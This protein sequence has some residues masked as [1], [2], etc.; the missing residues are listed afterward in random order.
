MPLGTWAATSVLI[1]SLLAE[2]LTNLHSFLIITTNHAGDDMY[3]F[4]T[5]VTRGKGEF[6]FRQVVGSTN[7]R[8]GSDLNDFLHGF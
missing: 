3:A 6:Y 4:E 1:N 5:P 8:T 2:W 7:F